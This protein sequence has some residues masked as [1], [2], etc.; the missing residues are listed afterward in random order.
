MRRSILL[1]LSLFIIATTAFAGV[2]KKLNEAQRLFNQATTIEQFQNV[3][4]RFLAAKTDVGYVAAEHD[5]AINE[6]IRKCDRKIAELS[7][8]LSLSTSSIS[9]SADGGNYTI[10][11][12]T[13]QGS[14][15]VNGLPSWMSVNSKGASSVSLYC[16]AN[17][18][19]SSRSYSFTI[20]AGGLS[21]SVSVSQR[22]K[23]QAVNNSKIKVVRV[24][25][26]NQAN[27]KV[28]NSYGDPFYF[29]ETRRLATRMTYDGPS[30]EVT[31][32]VY[33]K[34][35]N[36]DGSLM[37]YSGSPAGYTTSIETTFK[38]GKG[39]YAYLSAYGNDTRSPY[40]VGTV[41]YELW[42]DG[43]CISTSYITINPGS[44]GAL[45]VDGQSSLTLNFDANGGTRTLSVS[46]AGSD[47]STWGIPSFCSVN[48]GSTSFTLTCKPNSS[49]DSRSDYMKIKSGDKEVR[50]DIKQEGSSSSITGSI[51]KIWMDHNV[52]QNGEKGMKIH[53]KFEVKNMKGHKGNVVAYFYW[54]DSNDTPLKD[55]DNRYYTVDGK[56]SAC[57]NTKITPAYDT[58][59]YNDWVIFMPYNQFH[60]SSSGTHKLKF[61][62]VVWDDT[63]NK[64]IIKSGWQYITYTL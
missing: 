17:P 21:R 43:E 54:D 29:D 11:V 41:R 10:S 56:V 35:F 32:T 34:I 51:E 1:L 46:G 6:G 36:S 61:F 47:W 16:S 24:D 22:G 60:I 4:K 45:L 62:I 53:T 27:G 9:F 49:Y 31:K 2:N 20:S 25:F 52:Y 30:S 13:N 38:P 37:T 64:E 42:L 3:K 58:T 55:F 33:T 57:D 44:P 12:S 59:T 23:Q 14:F 63:I 15:S 50:I 39:N 8:N 5:A 19:T 26:A 28:L 7:P 40:S 18:S 48:K